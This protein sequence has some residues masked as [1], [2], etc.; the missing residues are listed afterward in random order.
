M[1]APLQTRPFLSVAALVSSA[2]ELGSLWRLCLLQRHALPHDLSLPASSFPPR[3]H[4]VPG[5]GL[6]R[7][8]AKEQSSFRP[9]AAL[10]FFRLPRRLHRH[11]RRRGRRRLPCLHSLNRV[12]TCVPPK[13]PPSLPQQLPPPPCPQRM[14]VHVSL[15]ASIE[16]T[17]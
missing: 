3:K 17:K 7:T 5:D 11:R 12:Q 16:T 14:G 13:P 4:H 1:H 9:E 10:L 8:W 2:S 15:V 6:R